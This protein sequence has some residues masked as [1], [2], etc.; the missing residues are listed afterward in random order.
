MCSYSNLLT[1][2]LFPPIYKCALISHLKILSGEMDDFRYKI[3]IMQD[4]PRTPG[5]TR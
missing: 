2:T 3:G 1:T 5:Y 4:D